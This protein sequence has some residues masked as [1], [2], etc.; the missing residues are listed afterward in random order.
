MS[1]KS[2]HNIPLNRAEGDL[3]IKVEIEDG[4]VTNAWSSGIMFRGI[5]ELLVNRHALDGLVITPRICGIC[6]ITHLMAAVRALD[7]IYGVKVPD[8]AIRLR[9]IALMVE[10]IQSDVRHGFLMFMVDFVNH[11]YKEHSL[12]EEAKRRYEPFKGETTI[13]AIKETKKVLEIVAIIGGQWPHTSFMVPGGVVS[14]PDAKDLLQC[15]FLLARYRKWYEDKVLGCSLERWNEVKNASDLDA[16]LD[17]SDS[18]SMSELGFYIRFAREAGLNKI[19]KGHGNF[20]SYGSL[21][22]PDET[23]VVSLG[24]NGFFVPSGIIT[25]SPDQ[26]F[27]Q[28]KVTEHVAFSWYKD[29]TD[30]KHP[31]EGET[32]PHYTGSEDDKYSWAKAPRYDGI[33]AETG[34]LAEMIIGSNPLFTDLIKNDGPNAFNRE[35]ARLVRPVTLMDAMDTWIK[36]TAAN[37]GEFYLSD[38]KIKNDE[39]FGLTQAT[40]GALGHWVKIK[41]EKIVHY[42]IITPTAWNGSPRD[43][44]GVRGPWEEALI[45]TKVN[46]IDNP[47]E[48]GHIIRS[49]DPCLVCTVHTVSKGQSTGKMV[50]PA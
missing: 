40:R 26:S 1:H 13:E 48:L 21:E 25:G 50:L 45:G 3:E 28:A 15:G 16:W 36:E 33:P 5:E 6:S 39:G 47:V 31:Y 22:M 24:N 18:H 43:S 32:I 38:G 20:I 46:D 17:E 11:A 35:L 9:N 27:D 34:P 19:G 49:F 42:Q 10:H 4:V 41:D 23:D 37:E 8:N 14:N 7:M 44:K 2:V 30:G 29:Y 12:Y